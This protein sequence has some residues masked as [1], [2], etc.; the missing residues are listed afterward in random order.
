MENKEIYDIAQVCNMLD[1]TSRTLRFYEEKGLIK[2][3]LVGNSARRHY[4]S[5]QISVIKDVL[6]LRTLGLSIK[7]ILMLQ[8]NNTELRDA[9]ISQKARIQSSINKK[10]SELILLNE[11]L[12]VIEA[13]NCIYEVNW[14]NVRFINGKEKEIVKICS[15]AIIKG[16]TKDLYEYLSPRMKNYMPENAYEIIRNDTLLPLG[17]F[18]CYDKTEID[19]TFPN[20]IYQYVKF[21]K[22]GLKITFVFF[23]QKI[24][25]LWL[26]YY[27]LER[28]EDL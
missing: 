17:E 27:D 19:R 20:K 7:S 3:T 16:K 6:V 18:V 1:T 5:E 12:A 2:S 28:R 21:T 14:K 23:H 15:D 10:V 4:T 11:A 25:G 26:S 22:L 9:V 13:E 8:E 24:G